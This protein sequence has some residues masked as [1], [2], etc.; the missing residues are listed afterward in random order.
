MTSTIPCLVHSG[1]LF[2]EMDTKIIKKEYY[3]VFPTVTP[4]ACSADLYL[5]T[6]KK[7]HRHIIEDAESEKKQ[8]SFNLQ[9][10]QLLIQV[11]AERFLT[12]PD[13]KFIIYLSELE[14]YFLSVSYEM[15]GKGS[16]A[17]IYKRIMLCLYR[18]DYEYPSGTGVILR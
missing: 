14:E 10:A 2:K 4:F 3:E 7:R 13:R 5:L 12:E 9:E 16:S 17:E 1:G 11:A 18:P 15:H 8:W 6:E